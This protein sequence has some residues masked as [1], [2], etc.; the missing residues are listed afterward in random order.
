[1]DKTNE[2]IESDE[3]TSYD[4]SSE[5]A[6]VVYNT[7]EPLRVRLLNQYT[8]EENT[9]FA[10]PCKAVGIKSVKVTW[11]KIY[12]NNL[13]PNVQQIRNVLKITN[14]H[15]INHGIYQCTIEANCQNA[16]ATTFIVVERKLLNMNK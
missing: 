13:G 10:L 2:E 7:P 14:A 8:V 16:T 3:E 15:P 12:D 1:M 5:L 9:D 11:Q 6:H 4:E